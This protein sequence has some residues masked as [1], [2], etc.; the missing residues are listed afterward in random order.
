MFGRR[1]TDPYFVVAG[2]ESRWLL[3]NPNKNVF[4]SCGW[5]QLTANSSP[6]P[7]FSLPCV[8]QKSDAKG[9]VSNPTI[10]NYAK[11]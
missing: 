7:V 1:W 2:C 5:A 6:A 10:L 9:N 3:R 11:Q 4:R 8:S